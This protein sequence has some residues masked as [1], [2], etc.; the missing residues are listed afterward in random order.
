M[1]IHFQDGPS[2]HVMGGSFIPLI[3]PELMTPLTLTTS[4]D[5]EHFGALGLKWNVCTKV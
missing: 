4:P 5:L 1:V 2:H 3:A